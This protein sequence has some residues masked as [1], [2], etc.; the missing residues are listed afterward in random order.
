VSAEPGNH[1]RRGAWLDRQRD[2]FVRQVYADFFS[3][4]RSFQNMS[5]AYCRCR[6][7][8]SGRC[9]LLSEGYAQCRI[10]DQLAALIGTEEE[11]GPL[12]LLHDL[13]QRL[14]P[15]GG[16]GRAAEE[17]LIGWL[18]SSI[19]HEAMKL[20]EDVQ[21][22]NSS[23]SSAFK[24]RG[25]DNGLASAF[26]LHR[27]IDRKG[28]V[29]RVAVDVMR[30]ME[31]LGFLFGQTSNMLRAALPALVTN[32]LLIRFLV[33]HE[34]MVDELWGEHLASIFLD[35]F[36][37]QAG[38]GFCAAGRSYMSGHWHTRALVMYRRALDLDRSCA[39]AAAKSSELE[40]LIACNS[41]FLEAA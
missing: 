35:M 38:Q 7:S 41:S 15:E 32:I 40:A 24:Q 14:W 5:Q 39:E 10:W 33:E 20:K 4:M 6:A 27:V 28:I 23:T 12:R 37:G 18:I 26:R 29:R 30:Q 1:R 16:Q 22:L 17:P 19:F 36:P 25:P 3:L 8:E 21:I 34:D 9:Y 31:Q 2:F 13:C 11:K